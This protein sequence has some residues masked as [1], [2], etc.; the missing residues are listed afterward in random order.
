MCEGAG[1]G[2]RGRSAPGWYTLPVM[3]M[4]RPVE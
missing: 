2:Y 4:Y 3:V 1:G